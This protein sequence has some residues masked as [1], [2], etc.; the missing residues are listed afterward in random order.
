MAIKVHGKNKMKSASEMEGNL[1][2]THQSVSDFQFWHELS[3]L[4]TLFANNLQS[5]VLCF[6]TSCQGILEN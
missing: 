1:S 4:L 3:L 2:V 6:S 5:H